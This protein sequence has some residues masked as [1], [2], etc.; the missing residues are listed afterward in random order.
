[1]WRLDDIVACLGGELAGDPAT[2]VARVAPLESAGE[3][4]IAFLAN[5]KYQS[6]LKDCR[7]SALILAPAAREHAAGRAAIIVDEPYLYFARVAGLFNPPPAVVPGV[8]PA[9]TVECEVPA[10]VQI[11]PG[12]TVEAGVV[13]GEEV[14]IGPG[15]HVGAG[16][17]IGA[18]T[19]LGPRVTIYHDCVIGSDCLFHAGVVIGADGFGFARHKDGRWTKI[20]QV[21]R[22]VI[23]DEVEIGANTTIDR[24]A[25]GDTVIG[26]GV[27]LDNLIQIAHNVQI[28]EHTA[29][30]GCAGVAGSAKIGA[31]CLIGGQAGISGH[32][33]VADDVVVSAWTLVPKSITRPGVYTSNLPLQKHGDWVRNFS[34]LR[35][36]DALAA[37]V[38]ALEQK[39]ADN[40]KAE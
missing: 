8:H 29:M 27:K 12:A 14:V 4:E 35:H 13:L 19:R 9:A 33:T 32:L 18:R 40:D 3:G 24:G 36:L 23:G 37:R 31:R 28:G 21:G 26:N 20:P 7:A 15:S 10:S 6:Q 2:R 34:H 30:A 5:P 16:T 25:L 38:R 22:V 17:R 39:L 11:G 1:M